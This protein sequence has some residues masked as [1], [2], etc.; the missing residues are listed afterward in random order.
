MVV[1]TGEGMAV[2][3]VRHTYAIFSKRDYFF[4][5]LYLLVLPPL[6]RSLSRTLSRSLS[7]SN[8]RMHMH[9]LVGFRDSA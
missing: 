2:V 3:I 9:A 8:T 7:P 1:E 5:L 6:T 4:L